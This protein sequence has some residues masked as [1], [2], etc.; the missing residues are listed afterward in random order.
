MATGIRSRTF[1]FLAGI[2]ICVVAPCIARS[3]PA[4]YT[5][6]I[7]LR[8]WERQVPYGTSIMN[9]PVMGNSPSGNLASLSGQGPAGFTLPA[10]Q[11]T[12]M[13]SL[14]DPSPAPA[15]LDFRSTNFTG[16]NAG[17]NFFDGGAPGVANFTPLPSIPAGQFGVTF[18]YKPNRFGGV[19]NLL[20]TFTWNGEL[21][22][23]AYCTYRTAI[24][25]SP[26]GGPVGGTA[27]AMAYLGGTAFP[28]TFVT[29]TVWGFPW[30]TGMVS[31]IAAV[32]GTSSSSTTTAM[33]ADSRTASGLGTLNLVTPFLVRVKSNPYD[34]GGCVNKWYYAG[35]ADAQ[36]Q[37]VPEPTTGAVLAAGAG[38]LAILLR[39]LKRR[40][41]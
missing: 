9:P 39:R 31:G 40:K 8:L 36:I 23:C 12:L 11:I 15:S 28:G 27:T 3:G 21:A 41:L 14:V 25:L 2:A 24:P 6:E 38:T 10:G 7:Q 37:F 32:A 33:G 20:G 35:I 16:A 30:D 26:I 18:S 29:A 4:L 13:T 5:S 34:C 1:C 19:M 22:A 17:G